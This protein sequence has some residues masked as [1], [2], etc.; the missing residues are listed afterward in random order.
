MFPDDDIRVVIIGGG[1]TGVLLAC[2]LLRNPA[3]PVQ[4]TIVEKSDTAG[5][6]LAYGTR[7]STSSM[8]APAI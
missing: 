7:R 6:G 4:G 8:S 5:L 1:A 2:H 3:R